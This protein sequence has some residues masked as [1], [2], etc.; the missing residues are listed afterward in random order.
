[1]GKSQKFTE[2]EFERMIDL[3]NQ[4]YSS[5]KI[6]Q[7]FNAPASS[8]AGYIKRRIGVLRSN[9]VN[10]RLY[11]C[12]GS[13]FESI[14]TPEK[15]YW[16]GFIYADG[17]LSNSNKK[18]IFGLSLA[19]KDR[20]HLCKLR[21]FLKATNPIS[22]YISTRGYSKGKPYVRM[23]IHDYE[24]YDNLLKNGVFL[25]KT[26]ILKKPNIPNE[27]K[28]H[29]IRGYFDGDGCLTCSSLKDNGL[30]FKVKIVGVKDILDYIKEFI[31]S[32]TDIRIKKY[33]KRRKSDK[34]YSLDVSGNYQNKEILDLL[35]KD[36]T[37][38]LERK[39]NKYKKLCSHLS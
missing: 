28:S 9:K 27:L 32:N 3:Y 17:Y 30:Q 29:F 39:C 2:K 33:Y 24:L 16:L 23:I 37:V 14:D 35:Y 21:S 12:D 5:V 10:S 31:E 6:G 26:L 22:E 34:V 18:K 36:S 25:R 1:M 38:C 20:E 13:C 11:T 19:K 8:V 4:G 15:A 7:M